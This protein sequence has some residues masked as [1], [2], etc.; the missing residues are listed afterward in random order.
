MSNPAS[1]LFS[2]AFAFRGY[3]TTNLGRTAE[4]LA[5]P[6]YGAT[7]KRHLTEAAQICSHVVKRPIDLISR[8][9]RNEEATLEE[10]DEAV[11]LIVAVE[12]AQVQILRDHF[13]FDYSK[14]HMAFGYSLGEIAA[15]VASNMLSLEDALTVPLAM[16]KECVELAHDATLGVLFSRGPAIDLAKVDWL[17]LQINSE[18]MGVIGVSS[19]LAPNSILL[20]GQGTTI[21]RFSARMKDCF[22]HRLY[23]R[24][25]E[26]RW[27]PMHTPI[28]WQRAIPNRAAVMLHTIKPNPKGPI[29]P[30]FSLVTGNMS[31]DEINCREILT[32][33]VDHPQ[34]LWDAVN[35]TLVL[36]C[37]AVVHVGPE[38]NLILATFTRLAENVKLQTGARSLGGFGLRAVASAVGR[39]WLAR[40]LPSRS[41]L[42]R[43]P[44]L[45]QIIL[46]DWL[47][48]NSPA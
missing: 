9:Q 35:E 7:V 13:A 3:N 25:N 2:A 22:P 41:T 38:P 46:E 26:H 12:M 11:A 17:C 33:W 20:I 28:I 4:F 37:K 19:Y 14:V 30:V 43:A 42:L 39:P 24:K 6:V 47:L 8:V 21:D 16:A 32:K 23:L 15:L 1:Q 5:H 29:P 18:G 34:R 40:M 31:Y 36:N 45:R 10:Y 44:A 27:P 48:E